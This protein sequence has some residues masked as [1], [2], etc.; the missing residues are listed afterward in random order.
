G[1]S[2]PS[3]WWRAQEEAL[4]HHLLLLQPNNY[5][6]KLVR[7]L[8]SQRRVRVAE[9]FIQNNLQNPVSLADIARASGCSVRS[10]T[11][12]FQE[13]Y[14]QPPMAFMRH[15]RLEGVRAELKTAA[16]GTRVTDIALR[17]GFGHLGRFS[18]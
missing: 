7:P 12:A 15:A 6:E 10:L 1:A 4:I 3:R 14:G 11:L 2:V 9:E 18:S 13:Q 5:T 17:W 16:P 8:S